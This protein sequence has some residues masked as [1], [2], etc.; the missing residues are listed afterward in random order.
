LNFEVDLLNDSI[1]DF[2]PS[3]YLYENKSIFTYMRKWN[4]FDLIG[5]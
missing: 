5:G 4:S 1:F 3:M 2:S